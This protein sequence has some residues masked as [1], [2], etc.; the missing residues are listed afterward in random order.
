VLHVLQES[1]RLAWM[2]E[3]LGAAGAGGD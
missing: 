3:A 1:E 2:K